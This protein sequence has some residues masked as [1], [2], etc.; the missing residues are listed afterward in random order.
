MVVLPRG[1]EV[2]HSY[3]E[4][5]MFETL[6]DAI[7]EVI[8]SNELDRNELL[9]IHYADNGTIS[10][11]NIN[12]ILANKI[13]TEV[14]SLISKRLSEQDE[15]PVYVPLGAFS[16]NMYFMGKGPNLKFVLVQRGCVQTDFEHVFETAGINQTMY[17]LKITLDADVALML[18]HYKTNTKMKTSAILSQTIINGDCPE[19]LLKIYEG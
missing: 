18:P 4:T 15:M 5:N 13:K 14:S 3:A 7:E 1:A 19:Q 11:V 2:L 6:N 12:Y 17:T 8:K 16:N 9:D 10:S